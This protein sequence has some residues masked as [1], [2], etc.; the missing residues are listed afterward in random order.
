MI[1][2]VDY[3]RVKDKPS[4]IKHQKARKSVMHTTETTE[5][6]IDVS[7]SSRQTPATKLQ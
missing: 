3:K 4:K 2:I 7:K 5:L 6:L 1:N